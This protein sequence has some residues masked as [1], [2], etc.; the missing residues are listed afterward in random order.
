MKIEDFEKLK[1]GQVLIHETG[2]EDDIILIDERDKSI[3]TAGGTW[4][5]W[6]DVCEE[7]EIK[8]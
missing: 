2:I 3:I 8:E 1:V 5:K 7:W 4:D 6:E